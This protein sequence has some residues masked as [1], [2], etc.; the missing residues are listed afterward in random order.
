MGTSLGAYKTWV[1]VWVRM[2]Y[3]TSALTRVI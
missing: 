3:I 2:N 1:R